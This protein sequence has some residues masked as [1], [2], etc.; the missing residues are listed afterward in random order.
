MPYP[1]LFPV[2]AKAAAFGL[3]AVIILF[4]ALPVL[5]LGSGIVAT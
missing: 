4:A 3:A 2:A 1:H 5:A